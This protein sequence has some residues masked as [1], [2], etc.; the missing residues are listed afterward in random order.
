MRQS[1]GMPR[2]RC[3]RSRGPALITLCV[4]LTAGMQIPHRA[5]AAA[6]DAYD[7]LARQSRDYVIATTSMTA[8]RTW[9]TRFDQLLSEAGAARRLGTD[10]SPRDPRWQ[11][12]R[13]A[14]LERVSTV[15]AALVKQGQL[16]AIIV[17]EYRRA[18]TPAEARNLSNLLAG[19][20]GPAYL[21]QQGAMHFI[22]TNMTSGRNAP[23]PGSPEWLKQM[24][25][26]QKEFNTG[27]KGPAP[28]A[29]D[30]SSRDALAKSP[31]AG[32]LGRAFTMSARSFETQVD[33]AVN[34]LLFDQR[35]A[36]NRDID[37]A[38]A[39]RR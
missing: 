23:K 5:T 31:A 4:L 22:V 7:A 18:I 14:L 26:L 33:G 2:P 27:F 11:Q 16:D 39:T 37:K 24:S 25:E 17:R 9:S 1:L 29:A 3:F 20:A 15:H 10:W 6:P 30:A 28:R 36:I 32:K 34:L 38:I 21:R 12:A 19:P 13:H 8:T 35:D